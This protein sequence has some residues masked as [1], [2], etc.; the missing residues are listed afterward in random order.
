MDLDMAKSGLDSRTG[1]DMIDFDTDMTDSN[2]DLEK[3]DVDIEG[4]DRDMQEDEDTLN[5][6]AYEMNAM[7]GDDVEFDLHDVDNTVHSPEPVDYEVSEAPELQTQGTSG[8]EVLHNEGKQEHH[9]EP[10]NADEIATQRED[11]LDEHASTHEIDYEF[12]DDAE[13]E[14]PH[15]NVTANPTDQPDEPGQEQ[16]TDLVASQGTQAAGDSISRP[17]EDAAEKVSEERHSLSSHDDQDRPLGLQGVSIEHEEAAFENTEAEDLG[18]DVHTQENTSQGDEGLQEEEVIVAETGQDH[19]T[20]D[21]IEAAEDDNYDAGEEGQDEHK[22]DETVDPEYAELSKSD[23]DL[24]EKPNDDFPAITVQYKGDE[25]PMFSTTTN[26]FFAD[27]SVLDQPLEELLAGLRTELENEVAMDDDLVLQVDEL[28]LE[29]SEATKGELIS[30]VT[31]R[32]ILEIFDLL[33]KNQDPDSSRT[34]Y[35]YLFTKPNV[36]KRLESLIES[37]TAGKGLDEVI[38]LFETPMTVDTSMLETNATIDG[39]H[40]ELDEFDSPIDENPGEEQN[41]RHD[42]A[43]DG[44]DD[45]EHTANDNTDLDATALEVQEAADHEGDGQNNIEVTTEPQVAIPADA[46]IAGEALLDAI[47]EPDVAAENEGQDQ[48]GKTTSPSTSFL[49]CYYPEFCLC[50]PCV[51]GY[52]ESRNREETEYRHSLRGNDEPI[53]DPQSNI[54]SRSPFP[55]KHKHSASDLSTTFSFNE[56]DEFCPA[57]AESDNDPFANFELGDDAEVNDNVVLEA[58]E[59]TE[60]NE[61]DEPEAINA[62][63]NGTSTTTTLQ[64]EEEA[65]SFN[66]DLGEVSTEP[67]AT[68][69]ADNEENDLDE[70]DW[71]DEPEADD[72]DPTTP[73]AAGKRSRGDDDEHNA[74]DEQDAKRR[75]S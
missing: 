16:T 66:I 54:L 33:V 35:T 51:S 2:Q 24:N 25:F 42:E 4:V 32:Q 40:E 19:E 10:E 57:H 12:E 41:H 71:R 13:L 5:H 72:Q 70:I 22:N 56:T 74:E 68:G 39:V 8:I 30:N 43:G 34:M 23:E 61:F 9:G 75:R 55:Y 18:T 37:A 47:E 63:T 60:E 1:D 49:C 53:R 3:H 6:H 64:E 20:F 28:G 44:E 7:M 58:T 14:Q 59:E 45:D 15:Q 38:H 50:K 65:A 26:S 62:Q 46:T 27:T 73:S 11:V 17:E 52:V 67:E 48:N 31:F 36:E 29:I 69:K 21:N